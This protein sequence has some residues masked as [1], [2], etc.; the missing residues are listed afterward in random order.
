MNL[1]TVLL[2]GGIVFLAFL[3]KGMTGFGPAIIVITF[4]SLLFHPHA[5]IPLSSVL[6]C[7]AG[8][9][10][11]VC[12]YKK[13]GWRY[14]LP[15]TFSIMAGAVLGS[16][17]LRQVDVELMNLIIAFSIFILGWWFVH[18]GQAKRLNN[19]SCRLPGKT[20]CSDLFVSL[21]AGWLG[22]FIGISSPPLIW[23]VGRQFQKAAFRQVLIPVFL[24]AALMRVIT[25]AG[26]G[27]IHKTNMLYAVTA[28]PFLLAGLYVGNHIFYQLS[29]KI[30][31]RIVGIVLIVMASR[32]LAVYFLV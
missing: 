25:Y 14:W 3:L 10:L 24:G 17:L 26:V 2:L 29:E 15:M 27:L 12:Q 5:L 20:R 11:L 22:G 21:F 18:T 4:G 32:M 16:V 23:H 28:L 13:D 30:F 9:I 8:L 1:L 7:I 19:L 31:K 6:D